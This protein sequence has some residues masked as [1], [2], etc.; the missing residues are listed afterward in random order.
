MGNHEFTFETRCLLNLNPRN[1]IYFCTAT[2]SLSVSVLLEADGPGGYELTLFGVS[3][4]FQPRCLNLNRRNVDLF[5]DCCILYACPVRSG[6]TLSLEWRLRGQ[7]RLNHGAP[8]FVVSLSVVSLSCRVLGSNRYR[9]LDK[10][11]QLRCNDAFA[12]DGSG[13]SFQ[14]E[15][16]I[17]V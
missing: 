2:L 17:T 5:L 6:P 10:V 1:V 16:Q 9:Y 4:F 3:I 12:N 11:T 14:L 13:S 15:V 8:L 7:L